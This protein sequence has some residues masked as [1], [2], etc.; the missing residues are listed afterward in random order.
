MLLGIK[1][2]FKHKDLQIFSVNCTNMSNFEVVPGRGS[3]TQLQVGE[4]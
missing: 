2:V 4:K 1:G 3:E